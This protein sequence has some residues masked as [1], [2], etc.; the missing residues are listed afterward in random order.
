MNSYRVDSKGMCPGAECTIDSRK[1]FREDVHFG[2]KIHVTLSQQG[3]VFEFDA[4]PDA[5]Y[6]RQMD[7]ALDFGMT[8]VM[9]YWGDSFS[10]MQ[11][12]DG[13]TGCQGDDDG[14]IGEP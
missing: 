12:L 13:M 4:C 14:S 6:V 10:R 9:S 8:L 5:G 7:A 2:D 3:L 1:P 11:W